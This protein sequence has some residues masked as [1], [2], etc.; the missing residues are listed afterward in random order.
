MGLGQ[1]WAHL[2]GLVAET[3]GLVRASGLRG[4]VHGRQLAE[5]PG[6]DALGETKQVGLLAVPEFTKVL[7]GS[8]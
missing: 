7:V 8:L 2:L 3:A 4:P 5:L 6:A 1:A